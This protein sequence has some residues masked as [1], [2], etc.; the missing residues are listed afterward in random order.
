M[1]PKGLSGLCVGGIWEPVPSPE[2]QLPTRLGSLPNVGCEWKP[3][4]GNSKLGDVVRHNLVNCFLLRKDKEA[5][6]FN[7]HSNPFK[8]FV[9]VFVL[10]L[11]KR[12]ALNAF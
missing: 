9:F 7:P 10:S 1:L 11:W 4:G 12:M 6:V 2:A 5:K 3:M 8:I